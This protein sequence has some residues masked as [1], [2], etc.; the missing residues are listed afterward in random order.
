VYFVVAPGV[1][2]VDG[3]DNACACEDAAG[4]DALGP[5]VNVIGRGVTPMPFGPRASQPVGSA[6]NFSR[7]PGEQ[8]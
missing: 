3:F 4:A 1:V 6:A 5:R 8:K 7:Q 2:A